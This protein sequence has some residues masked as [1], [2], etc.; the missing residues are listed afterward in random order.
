MVDVIDRPPPTVIEGAINMYDAI[1]SAKISGS[2]N[3]L[4]DDTHDG[5]MEQLYES[6]KKVYGSDY[7]KEYI[8]PYFVYKDVVDIFSKLGHKISAVCLHGMSIYDEKMKIKAEIPM[9][10]DCD[11]C[12]FAVMVETFPE[13][14]HVEY[15]QDQ[16]GIL[17]E[18]LRNKLRDRLKIYG[19]IVGAITPQEVKNAAIEAGFYYLEKSS[20]I[21]KIEVPEGFVPREW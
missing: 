7:C 19:V 16:M 20:G 14:H 1:N 8:D 6:G 18:T 10:M 5:S 3:D 11:D 9:T 12:F 4:T 21:M 2:S 13:L 15:L 17:Q